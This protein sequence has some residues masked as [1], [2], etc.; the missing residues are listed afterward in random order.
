M[1]A[2]SSSS[3]SSDSWIGSD[4]TCGG[5]STS[6]SLDASNYRDLYRDPPSEWMYNQI[7][8]A[9]FWSHEACDAVRAS[10][11]NEY[12]ACDDEPLSSLP[13][14]FENEIM[15]DKAKEQ[16]VKVSHEEELRLLGA[17]EPMWEKFQRLH[18]PGSY[19]DLRDAFVGFIQEC[20]EQKQKLSVSAYQEW[21]FQESQNEQK[22][23]NIL[24]YLRL[25]T[26]IEI[27]TE[28]EQF[29]AFII[30]LDQGKPDATKYCLEEVLPVEEDAQQVPLRVVNIDVSPIEEPNIHIIY[31][32]PDSSVPTVTLLYRPGHYDIIYE[33]S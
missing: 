4:R 31:E 20:M 6:S 32:S 3:F 27:C 11:R 28:V 15:K 25:V 29:K 1:G 18:L 9:P 16:L 26:A 22:F 10:W 17:L 5:A 13:H 23:V 2:S 24:L 30:D 7:L 19:S 21:L 8:E 14:E 33:K 12:E